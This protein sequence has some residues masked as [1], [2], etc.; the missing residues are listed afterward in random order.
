MFSFLSRL[1]LPGIGVSS[2]SQEEED[3]ASSVGRSL[4]LPWPVTES[5]AKKTSSTTT[6]Q[7]WNTNHGNLHY[8]SNPINISHPIPRTP[9]SLTGFDPEFP[10]PPSGSAYGEHVHIYGHGRPSRPTP[11]FSVLGQGAWYEQESMKLGTQP[12]Y[13]PP[14]VVRLDSNPLTG[15]GEKHQQQVTS[16]INVR[17]VFVVPV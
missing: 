16:D 9:N 14:E 5:S 10:A 6:R 3:D 17:S 8:T 2:S 15:A 11:P 7:E 4:S 13:S 1:R 12:P